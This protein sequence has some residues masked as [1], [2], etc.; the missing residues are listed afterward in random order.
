MRD[1]QAVKLSW[2]CSISSIPSCTRMR[3]RAPTPSMI[4]AESAYGYILLVTQNTAV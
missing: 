3:M 1:S 2:G 4:G